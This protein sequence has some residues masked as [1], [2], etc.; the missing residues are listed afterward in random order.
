MY[1]NCQNTILQYCI[2]IIHDNESN[3]KIII[4]TTIFPKMSI[5]VFRY[6][7]L[8][9]M[10]TGPAVIHFQDISRYCEMSARFQIK[11]CANIFPTLTFMLAK[12]KEAGKGRERERENCVRLSPLNH[13][14]VG[15]L[16]TERSTWPSIYMTSTSAL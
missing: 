10:C 12:E 11:Y 4:I 13:L 3:Y 9:A 2:T 5:S 7:V 6:N 14:V 16:R 8:L 15:T 1:C